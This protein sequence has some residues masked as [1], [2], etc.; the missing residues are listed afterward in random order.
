MEYVYNEG[1]I[2]IKTLQ[3]ID[4][5]DVPIR[6]F[7]LSADAVR[8]SL[9][10]LNVETDSDSDYV[11]YNVL[12]EKNLVSPRLLDKFRGTNN[13]RFANSIP[14]LVGVQNEPFKEIF[15]VECKVRKDHRLYKQ[16]HQIRPYVHYTWAALPLNLVE[17]YKYFFEEMKIG[18]IPL[19][20]DNLTVFQEFKKPPLSFPSIQG[21]Y[22]KIQHTKNLLA[23]LQG[24]ERIEWTKDYLGAHV[25]SGTLRIKDLLKILNHL[26]QKLYWTWGEIESFATAQNNRLAIRR[27]Q[28]LSQSGNNLTLSNG[29]LRMVYLLN[30]ALPQMPDQCDNEMIEKLQQS[31]IF[32]EKIALEMRNHFLR[33]PGIQAFIH[34]MQEISEKKN[35]TKISMYDIFVYLVETERY[36]LLKWLFVGNTPTT[37]KPK[38]TSKKDICFKCDRSTPCKE[39][40]KKTNDQT[41]VLLD[42]RQ[43]RGKDYII[44]IR[45]SDNEAFDELIENPLLIK[46][47]VPYSLVVENKRFLM[48][49]GILEESEIMRKDQ[50]KYCPYIDYWELG[51]GD[52][53]VVEYL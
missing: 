53:D 8:G 21:Y 23:E 28:L 43:D 26:R 5:M 46:F 24:L 33:L 44:R 4:Q 31:D 17:R 14:D 50:G 15:A 18:Y 12:K 19:E 9:V 2:V 25:L 32:K 37:A 51:I 6:D 48:D 27:L 34:L 30:E 35:C 3:T 45:N 38:I 36:N 52:G 13:F 39:I 40:L 42:F 7:W 41:N 20:N 22:P 11:F 16:I 47:L 49:L 10:A 29:S 1:A